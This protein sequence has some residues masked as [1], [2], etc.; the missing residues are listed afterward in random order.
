MFW[1]L[2]I[3]NSATSVTDPCVYITG[4]NVVRTAWLR[5]CRYLVIC[6]SEIVDLLLPLLLTFHIYSVSDIESI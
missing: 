1:V 5:V 3:M 2:T 4:T 6:G